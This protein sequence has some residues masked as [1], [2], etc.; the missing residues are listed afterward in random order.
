M[1][2]SCE[3]I[4]TRTYSTF[5]MQCVLASI[6]SYASSE[7]LLEAG[8]SDRLAAQKSFFTKARLLCDLGAESGQLRL[9]Q[10]SLVL[11][12]LYFSFALD[13][14]Y[15]FWLSNAV[16]LAT[17]MGLHRDNIAKDLDPG[18][19]KLFR[20]IWWMIYNRDTLLH[21][22]GF[23][24][25]RRLHDI[26]FDTAELTEADWEME[27]IPEQF[28]YILPP[29]TRLHKVVLIENCKL[30]RISEYPPLTPSDS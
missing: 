29:I 9:Q 14:D 7:L 20:R 13:K 26:D 10:G 4:K 27:D 11:S 24:N 15:R 6:V 16:H 21:L 22:S 23:G 17:L 18:T 1:S 25:V 28:K 30:S 5:L 3:N 8:F 19:R 12:L 2:S